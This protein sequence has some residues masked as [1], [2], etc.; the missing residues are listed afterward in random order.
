VNIFSSKDAMP[1]CV[2]FGWNYFF[3]YYFVGSQIVLTRSGNWRIDSLK[4]V[5]FFIA[6]VLILH[7]GVYK[8][9]TKGKKTENIVEVIY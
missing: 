8:N 6:A 2:F 7:K 9:Y 5:L 3:K 4:G 1:D